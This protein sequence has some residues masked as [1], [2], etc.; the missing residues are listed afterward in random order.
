M[1]DVHIASLIKREID[2]SSAQRV[3]R[4]F[5]ARFVLNLD[6]RGLSLNKIPK[7][8]LFFGGTNGDAIC[9]RWP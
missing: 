5:I 7:Q 8:L 9:T 2:M 6:H 1:A 3:A 4:E